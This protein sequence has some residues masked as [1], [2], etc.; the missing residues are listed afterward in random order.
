MSRLLYAGLDFILDQE[1][2]WHFIEANDHPVALSAADQSALSIGASVFE[3]Q[4]VEALAKHLIQ[5]SSGKPVCLLLPDCFVVDAACHYSPQLT[6]TDEAYLEDRT[7]ISIEEFNTFAKAIQA[8]G[9]PCYIADTEG[10]VIDGGKVFLREG[11]EVGVLYRRAY[12]FPSS[13]T[14]TPVINDLRYRAICT[15]KLLTYRLLQDNVPDLRIIPAYSME[16]EEELYRFLEEAQ[17]ER[18]PVI[19]KPR[20][21]A[22]SRSVNRVSAESLLSN[23]GEVSCCADYIYQP[24]IQ[25]ATLHKQH[26]DYYVDVRIYT[27]DG[28]PVAGFARQA[29]A[30]CVGVAA[31][32]PLSWLTTT[33][34]LV[35]IT[36]NDRE[37]VGSFMLTSETWDLLHEAS[38]KIIETLEQ[39]GRSLSY[40]TAFQSL[41]PFSKQL[42]IASQMNKIVLASQ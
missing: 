27:L 30:P 21:G 35:P 23:K 36:R 19:C 6:F 1:G 8:L 28:K 11:T 18:T 10:V 29:A 38:R 37:D 24:W 14:S 17:R 9:R 3:G 20:R 42:G 7:R 25:P 16:D 5:M 12:R 41:S 40:E 22:N 39:Y 13:E 32:S 26:N 31:E 4:A 33:G 2:R 34:P 15:D